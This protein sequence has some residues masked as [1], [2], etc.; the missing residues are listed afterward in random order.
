M[1]GQSGSEERFGRIKGRNS[2]ISLVIGQRGGFG[3]TQS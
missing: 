2:F 1:A 3:Q